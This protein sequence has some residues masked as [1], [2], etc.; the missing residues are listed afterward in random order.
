MYA[1]S[2]TY[3]DPTPPQGLRVVI[4]WAPAEELPFDYREVWLALVLYQSFLAGFSKTALL[5]GGYRITMPISKIKMALFGGY[6]GIR[7]GEAVWGIF[8]TGAEI[9]RRYPSPSL[10][11]GSSS[12]IYTTAGYRGK[13][14]IRRPNT[15]VTDT[16]WTSTTS[17]THTPI[18][19]RRDITRSFQ[20]GDSGIEI[21]LD[22]PNLEIHY[23]FSGQPVPGSQMLTAFM[24]SV[25]FCSEYMGLHTNVHIMAFS[26]DFFFRLHMDRT[27]VSGPT[28]LNWHYASL[29]LRTLW[30]Q[31]VMRFDESTKTFLDQPRF[32]SLS[33]EIEYKEVR[34][35]G[36][37]I[38]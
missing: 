15:P 2:A 5:N 18:P 31:I 23:Q 30:M 4:D 25:T 38:G 3:R 19:T 1:I 16:N 34:I 9:A 35:G 32:E 33:Y 24:R 14:T 8:K 6:N 37:W 20:Y 11:L 17:A 26:S 12:S 21:S 36:G 22:D 28:Q 7:F 27:Q 13:L 10:V 29:A